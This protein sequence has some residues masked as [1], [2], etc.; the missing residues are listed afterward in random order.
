MVEKNGFKVFMDK[1][2]SSNLK[3]MQMDYV[4]QAD[5]EGFVLKGQGPSASSA[6]DCGSCAH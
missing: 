5:G 6:G 2:T 4:R 3:N 1:K